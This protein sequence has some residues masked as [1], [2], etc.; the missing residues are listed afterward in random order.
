MLDVFPVADRVYQVR[1]RL[2]AMEIRAID[3]RLRIMTPERA[4]ILR[5]VKY[6]NRFIREFWLARENHLRDDSSKGG[7]DDCKRCEQMFGA[8]ASDD[9]ERMKKGYKH[10]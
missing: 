6:V 1:T 10:G 7:A 9:W 3:L 8:H 2:L 4:A 5:H